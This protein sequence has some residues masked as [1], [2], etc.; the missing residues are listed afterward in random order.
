MET[1]DRLKEHLKAKEREGAHLHPPG[2]ASSFK[3]TAHELKN[4]TDACRAKR[5]L[6]FTRREASQEDVL[7]RDLS[8]LRGEVKA[9]RRPSY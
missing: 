6:N 5:A 1:D 8:D 3:V 4:G 9:E 7:L 2:S